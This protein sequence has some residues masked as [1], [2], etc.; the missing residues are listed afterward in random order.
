MSRQ[1]N[2]FSCEKNTS[3]KSEVN[4]RQGNWQTAAAFEHVRDIA[5]AV[6]VET[7]GVA[8]K[9]FFAPELAED[10]KHALG[11]SRCGAFCL[12]AGNS[13]CGAHSITGTLPEF[14]QVAD[15]PL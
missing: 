14:I 9:T 13:E 2:P 4:N 3:R 1:A 6:I 8:L 12:A 11:L 15:H 10:F 7:F 5:V